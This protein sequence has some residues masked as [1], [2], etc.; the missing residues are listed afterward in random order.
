MKKKNVNTDNEEKQPFFDAADDKILAF[1]MFRGP[2]IGL[3][4][5]IDLDNPGKKLNQDL[6]EQD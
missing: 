5:E 2:S 4:S 3:T 6:N 1:D